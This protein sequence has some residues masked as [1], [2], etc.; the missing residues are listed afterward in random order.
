MK[1]LFLIFYIMFL[2]TSCGSFYNVHDNIEANVKVIIR[3]NIYKNTEPYASARWIENSL[4][5]ADVYKQIN[6]NTIGSDDTLIPEIDFSDY[7]VLIIMMGQKPTGGFF[8]NIRDE[9]PVIDKDKLILYTDWLEPPKGAVLPQIIS[10]PYLM[11]K[12]KRQGYSQIHILDQNKR[13]R[14]KINK[15][16]N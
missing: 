3:G 15:K 11:L 1:Q 6:N 13:L 16:T 9:K 10:S 7:T 2:F 14:I 4:Q 8:L 12:L 5:L